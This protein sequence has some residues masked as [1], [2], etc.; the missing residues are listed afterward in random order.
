MPSVNDPNHQSLENDV[1]AHLQGLGFWCGSSTYHD[2]KWPDDVKRRL[3]LIDTPTA[4]YVRT[5]ADRVAIHHELPIVF[6]WECKTRDPRTKTAKRNMAVEA[7]PLAQHVMKA[8]LGVRILYCYRDSVGDI[9]VGFWCDF[10]PRI[11]CILIPPREQGVSGYLSSVFVNVPVIDI[12]RTSGSN[13]AF[14]LIEE[15]SLRMLPHWTEAISRVVEEGCA[16][17]TNTTRCR[18]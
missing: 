9:E 15:E 13:D 17:T 18:I 8:K 12:F 6:E 3:S 11:G 10:I 5:R 14:A 7:Y 2:G 1:C 4:L 16:K